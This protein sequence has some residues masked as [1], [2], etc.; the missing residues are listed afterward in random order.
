VTITN[1][2]T[3]QSGASKPRFRLSGQ[4]TMQRPN[5]TIDNT[6]RL[7]A[8]KTYD[9]ITS[10]P[11]LYKAGPGTILDILIRSNII[12]KNYNDDIIDI[13]VQAFKKYKSE[14][15]YKQANV[16]FD[17]T[18]VGRRL[19]QGENIVKITKGALKKVIR[20]E[21]ENLNELYEADDEKKPGLEVS[22]EQQ[23]GAVQSKTAAKMAG[24]EDNPMKYMKMSSLLA[25]KPASERGEGLAIW[26][27]DLA[28]N[29]IKLAYNLLDKAKMELAQ[30]KKQV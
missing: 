4:G 8:I 14:N 9:L 20:E 23:L 21:I 6:K 15:N 16:T 2:I 11:I 30:F 22:D 17:T 1:T 25:D 18:D 12:N 7:I 24:S 29:D 19:M 13:I 10:Y 27:M 28:N 3:R 26:A 5:T